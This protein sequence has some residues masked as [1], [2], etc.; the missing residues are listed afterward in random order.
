MKSETSFNTNSGATGIRQYF[1]NILTKENGILLPLAFLLGRASV[2]GGLMPFG[3]AVYAVT[4]GQK[5]NRLLLAIT[6][7]SG[8]LSG[9]GREQLYTAVASMVFFTLMMLPLGGMGARENVIKGAVGFVSVI[10]PEMVSVYLHGFLVYDMLRA[11]FNGFLVFSMVMVFSNAT[12]LLSGVRKYAFSNEEVISIA[13][14]AALALAGLGEFQILGITVKNVLCI[15]LILLFSYRS[16]PGVGAAIGVTVG[17]I[18]NMS[19]TSTPLVIGS[20]AFCGLLSGIFRKLGRPGS[21]LGF[22]LGNTVLT[23]YLSGSTEVFIYLKEIS[24]AAAVF[25][26]LPKSIIEGLAGRFIKEQGSDTDKAGYS[27]RIKEMAREKLKKFARAFSE[28][29]K[30]FS[31]ISDTSQ[32]AEKADITTMFDRVADK[33][34]KDCSLCMH[35]WDRNFY[36]TYQVLFNIV[37]KLETKGHI[38]TSDIPQHFIDKCERIYDFTAAVNNSYELFKM[39]MMWKGRINESRTLVAQQ[40]EGLSK[41]VSRL[42]D[43]IGRDVQFKEEMERVIVDQLN[44]AGIAATEAMAYQNHSG[45]YEVSLTLAGCDVKK[46]CSG[47]VEKLLSDVTGRRISRISNECSRDKK[48]GTCGMRFIEEELY[49]VTTGV[50]QLSKHDSKVSGDCYTF[51]NT[52]DGRYVT[53]LSDGMGSGPK[54][55]IHSRATVNMLEQFMETG[56]DQ[57]TALR[58]INSALVLK[59]GDDSYATI[60]MS[61]INLFDGKAEFV[62]FGAAPSFVKRAQRVEMV[63]T[64]SLPAGIMGNIDLELESKSLENGD[65]I[66]LMSDGVYDSFQHATD[67][68]GLRDF[69]D[70]IST[71][72]PQELADRIL[73]KAYANSGSKPEDDMIVIVSKVWKKY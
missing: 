64:A 22:I 36:S 15:I 29:A 14:I 57:D 31:E 47:T 19:T 42:G 9:G 33:V 45:K 10:I 67:K 51:L 23:L 34:C 32:V 52:G 12:P 20:Y 66:V 65:Y 11:F 53:A 25:I 49:S 6:V 50:A 60:D 37:E 35:C 55:S 44:K 69:I 16:G 72:N 21:A 30:T 38:D 39:D 63:R 24:L 58:L 2:T 70:S 27:K 71:L 43:E 8:I 56:F 68:E 5:F 17:L 46:P 54:A 48:S 41:V 40:L 61:V 13:I 18:M 4:H 73:D 7:L 62:K 1:N 3:M 59:S 26:L 28:L